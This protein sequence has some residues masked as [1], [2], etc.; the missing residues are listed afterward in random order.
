MNTEATLTNVKYVSVRKPSWGHKY[1][2]DGRGYF[3]HQHSHLDW[4]KSLPTLWALPWE[5]F[6]DPMGLS[7]YGPGDG[8]DHVNNTNLLAHHTSTALR[9][10]AGDHIFIMEKENRRSNSNCTWKDWG[11]WMFYLQMTLQCT[12][13]V[14]SLWTKY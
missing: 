9:S 11:K 2:G 5:G 14:L 13:K 3:L 8:C 6:A 12:V 4:R 7:H 10:H 1:L